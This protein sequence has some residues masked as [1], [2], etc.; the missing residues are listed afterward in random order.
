MEERAVATVGAER[1]RSMRLESGARRYP[2]VALGVE[3]C[4]IA[5]PEGTAPR[6]FADIFDGERHVATC[7]IVLAAPEG[8]YLRCTFK[9]RTIPRSAPPADFARARSA[10][11]GCGG[12]GPG[13][14]RRIRWNRSGFE[15]G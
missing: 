3:S 11:R 8:P 14:G 7:L 6:G 4:L 5:A 13:A 10:G 9:R 1:T 12:P 15:L 2:I